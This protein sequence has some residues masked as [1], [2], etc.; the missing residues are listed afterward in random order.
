[1]NFYTNTAANN[2]CTWFSVT[3]YSIIIVK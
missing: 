3:L 2:K 1:V